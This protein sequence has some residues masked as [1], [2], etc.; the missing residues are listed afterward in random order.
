MAWRFQRR[1]KILPGVTLN[2]GKRGA[3]LSIGRRGARASAG[4]RGVTASLSLVGTGL[5]YAWRLGRK[6]R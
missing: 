6:R 2:L 4:R 5:G 1:K 3:G